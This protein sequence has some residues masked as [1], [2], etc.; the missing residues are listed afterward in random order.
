MIAEQGGKIS[1]AGAERQHVDACFHLRML[2]SLFDPHPPP[3]AGEKFF[4]YLLLSG[5]ALQ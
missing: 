4:G 5:G 2:Q 1:K 3:I